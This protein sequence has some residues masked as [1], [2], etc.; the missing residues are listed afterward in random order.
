MESTGGE[1]RGGQGVGLVAA[2]VKKETE[3]IVAAFACTP[4]GMLA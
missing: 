2:E 3:N 4:I 1:G